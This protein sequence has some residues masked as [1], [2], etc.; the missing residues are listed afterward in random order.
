MYYQNIR[1][2]ASPYQASIG[3]MRG[4]C[5]HRHADIEINYAVK[6]GFD[7]VVNKKHYRI[8]EGE[9][10]VIS[11]MAAH[12]FP[13]RDA[14][15]GRVLTLVVG[16]AFL[17]KYFSCFANAP[18]D[19]YVFSLSGDT[20]ADRELKSLLDEVAALTWNRQERNELLI[21]GDLYK[22]CAHLI[23]L[24][25]DPADREHPKSKE[26]TK[27][28]NIEKALDLIYY[29]HA[30]PLT[31]EV[32]AKATGYGKSNFC[33]IFKSI[34][35]ETFHIALN[36]RRVESACALLAETDLPVSKISLEVGF[37][38]AKSFCRLFKAERG[39]TPLEYRR[40]VHHKERRTLP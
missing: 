21:R 2:E 5:E 36:R 4:F 33:K 10:L 29:D 15:E 34:T 20:A 40:S 12:S 11:P 14:E 26:M 35:G 37:S 39:M 3:P 31:V 16:I 19:A 9:V 7:A 38:E 23:E 24:I 8:N 27:V 25:N 30:K 6:E 17:K 22:I 13:N 32:A 18:R 1:S 28:A